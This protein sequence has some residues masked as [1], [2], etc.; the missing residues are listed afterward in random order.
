MS[1]LLNRVRQAITSP[2]GTG[3]PLVLSSTAY[4]NA[5]QTIAGA[6]GVDQDLITYIIEEGNDWEIQRGLWTSAGNTLARNTPVMSSISGV[7]G[8]TKMSLAGAATMRVIMDA[9]ETSLYRRV[10]TVTGTTDTITDRMKGQATIYNSA[11]AVAVGI[12]APGTNTFV[13]GWVHRVK[14]IGA[15]A[16]TITPT[17]AT[18]SSDSSTTSSLVLQQYESAIIFSDGTNYFAIVQR[19]QLWQGPYTLTAA[20]RTQFYQNFGLPAIIRNYIAGLIL[21]TAGASTS[22]SVTAGAAADSTSNDIMQ[23]SGLTKTTGAWA[24]GNATGALDTSTIANNT[25][26][27]VFLIKRPDTGVTDILISL[28]ATAPTLPTNYTIFRRIGAMRTNSS[29]QWQRFV[30]IDDKFLWYTPILEASNV[31]IAA[32]STTITISNIP[33]SIVVEAIFQGVYSHPT[34]GNISQ[35]VSSM[36]DTS[37][38]IL[39]NWSLYIPVNGGAD[40]DEFR[41]HTNNG[42]VVLLSSATGGSYYLS[43]HG[44]F[45]ARGKNG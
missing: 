29:G 20:Q 2:T 38:S 41:V 31:A 18:I 26:Y 4:S 23:F 43:T 14:N 8:T 36:I 6:G 28:S 16:V 45:D 27:Y 12:A 37:Q 33:P 9:D 42:Q 22:F 21:S 24:V 5:Y 25:W 34:S 15:G 40:G 39:G 32:T 7:A 11:S 10:R 30:Q 44:W 19:L 17:G 3:G 13:N 1:I 35:F